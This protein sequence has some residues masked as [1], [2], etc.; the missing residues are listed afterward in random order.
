[1]R[2]AATPAGL[3]VAPGINGFQE[4]V[5]ND[6]FPHDPEAAKKLMA[7]AGYADG[8]EV[9]LDCPNDRYVN[10]EEICTAIIPMLE[11]VKHLRDAELRRPSR[12]TSTRSAWP[13]TATTP[14]SS[15]WAG[16]RDFDDALNPISMQLMTT[17]QPGKLA[18]SILGGYCNK[19][20]MELTEQIKTETDEA[21]R[22]A[23]IRRGLP[24]PQGR[25]R[26]HSS[27]P[28]AAL[29]WGVRTD[30]TKSVWQRPF[31]DVDLRYVVMK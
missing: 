7:E 23:L 15:C 10:D 27:A 14:A 26:P 8:F 20:V 11:R 9:T 19:R 25:G 2:G 29:A 17:G 18:P 22:N 5:M 1:M 28:A 4:G 21:K 6:R 31:N 16:P 24:D 3:M 30:T 13:R 12:C